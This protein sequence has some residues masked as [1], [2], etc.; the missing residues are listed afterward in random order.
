MEKK[1]SDAEEELRK[2]LEEAAD[3]F[4]RKIATKESPG[5]V[6]KEYEKTNRKE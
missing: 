2:I 1:R 6:R 3:K 4:I 5:V